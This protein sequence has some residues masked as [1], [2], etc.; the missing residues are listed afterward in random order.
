MSKRMAK[1]WKRILANVLRQGKWGYVCHSIETLLWNKTASM[2]DAD[3]VYDAVNVERRRQHKSKFDVGHV[4][5][6]P[7]GSPRRIEWIKAQI[8]KNK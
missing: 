3:L 7:R 4:G 5:L 1:V 2:E 8:E 6:W